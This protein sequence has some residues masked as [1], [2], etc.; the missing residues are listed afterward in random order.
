MQ[1]K[2]LKSSASLVTACFSGD[3]LY[4]RDAAFIFNHPFQRGSALT[5]PL[6]QQEGLCP[7][8]LPS[9]SPRSPSLGIQTEILSFCISRCSV[10][11]GW[12]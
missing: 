3:K 7:H 12:C 10:C 6:L 2:Q 1:V 4:H 5:H 9:I 8:V 11:R